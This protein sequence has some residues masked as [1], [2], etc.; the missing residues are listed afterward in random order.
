MSMLL[1]VNHGFDWWF[2]YYANTQKV[3][4]LLHN[5]T[6]SIPLHHNDAVLLCTYP[7]ILIIHLVVYTA[8]DYKN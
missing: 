5:I 8:E 2:F 7:Y 1:L 6:T 4:W 3:V